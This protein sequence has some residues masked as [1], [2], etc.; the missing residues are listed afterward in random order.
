MSTAPNLA[1]FALFGAVLAAAGLP[2]YIHAPK[3][4]VD[5][6][7]VSLAAL[8]AVLFALRLI[9]VVQDPALGWL[10]RRLRNHRALA[11]AAAGGIL[12]LSMIGLFG[13]SPPINPVAWFA[14]TL[15]LLFSSFSFLTISF[16]AQG[17]ATAKTLGDNGHVRLAGWRETGALIGV[18]LAA[19]APVAL[20]SVGSSPFMI[21]SAIFAVCT[22]AA[23]LAM[24]T[25]WS[26]SHEPTSP[27]VMRFLR[28]PLARR[29][30]L[31][32]LLNATP[33]AVTSTLFLFFVESRL[34]APGWEGPLLLLFFVAAAL[35]APFW[36][37]LAQNI[38]AKP[39]L[40]LGMSLSILAFGGA[41]FLGT[42]DL[43]PFVI[44]CLASGAALG[45]D[46]TLLPAL[47]ATRAAEIA[48]EAAEGFGLWSFVSKLS[49]AFAAAVLLPLLDAAGLQSGVGASPEAALATL[50]FFYAILPCFLKL[51]ALALL[52]ATPLEEDST[53]PQ[54]NEV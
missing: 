15:T 51:A 1:P 34:E 16:Y 27:G 44:I 5:T 19:V 30:L 48:P 23:V 43:A 9:D 36:S 37:R 25:N 46:M 47:F 54:L 41:A 28:D 3:F 33:V 50:T 38:G 12:A 31:I 22:F 20:A 14:I 32:A 6:Y 35:C 26:A 8:G 4:Y 40:M 7:G 49:L 42:G 2:I 29:L 53:Q 52:A 39:A 18:S 21:F 10:S 13:V 11:V 45:A 24:R 17:V